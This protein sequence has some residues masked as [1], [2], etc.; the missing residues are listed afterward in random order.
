MVNDMF[1]LFKS[2]SK[3]NQIKPKQLTAQQMVEQSMREYNAR[4]LT[5]LYFPQILEDR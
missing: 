4:T 2:K 5:C 1:K 3:Q